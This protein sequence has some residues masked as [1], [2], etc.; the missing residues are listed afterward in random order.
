MDSEAR[1]TLSI[2]T[3]AYVRRVLL[4]RIRLDNWDEKEDLIQSCLT[5]CCEKLP[6]YRGNSESSLRS[7]LVTVALRSAFSILRKKY[8]RRKLG[9]KKRH[10]II[11]EPWVLGGHDK[12]SEEEA[13]VLLPKSDQP[14]VEAF[15]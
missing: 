9:Q 13:R 12:L 5:E 1:E 10:L 3:V 11:R 6:A 4:A 15:G 2:E 14:L 8:R 7:F